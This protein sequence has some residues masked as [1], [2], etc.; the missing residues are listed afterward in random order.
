MA[1]WDYLIIGFL[2]GEIVGE[3]IQRCKAKI[4]KPEDGE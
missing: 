4:G 3:Q 1:W 2:L